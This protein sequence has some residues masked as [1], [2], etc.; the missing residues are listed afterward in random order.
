MPT[1]P[2]GWITFQARGPVVKSKAPNGGLSQAVT[3]A[4]LCH[5]GEL[6][7]GGERVSTPQHSRAQKPTPP[8][9]SR[10]W[11]SAGGAK[12][13]LVRNAS[14]STASSRPEG[15]QPLGDASHNLALVPND[16][17]PGPSWYGSAQ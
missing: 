5:L 3:R 7:V 16:G 2:Y 17:K 4:Q 14:A 15:H 12:W 6:S 13:G 10:G 8:A 1:L 9:W 11:T